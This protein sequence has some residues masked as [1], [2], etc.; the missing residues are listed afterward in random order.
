MEYGSPH[1]AEAAKWEAKRHAA[2][3][4]HKTNK[5]SEAK[6]G[7]GFGHRDLAPKALSLDIEADEKPLELDTVKKKFA[8][9][10]ENTL[11][12]APTIDTS[13]D[14]QLD[15]RSYAQREADRKR[16]AGGPTRRAA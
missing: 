15:T 14:L 16:A 13:T 7:H 5:A 12:R 6:L 1:A 8:Y 3:D 2:S 9:G 4:V 10:G 11:G